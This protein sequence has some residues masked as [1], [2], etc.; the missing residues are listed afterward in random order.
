MVRDFANRLFFGEQA[1]RNL[2][3]IKGDTV[4]KRPDVVGL[5]NTK[6]QIFTLIRVRRLG[7]NEVNGR[8][9]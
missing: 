2:Q 9:E 1:S 3:V 5:K 6:W 4:L 8:S 7:F